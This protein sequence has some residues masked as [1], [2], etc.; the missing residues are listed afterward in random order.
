QPD[1][2]CL[3]L[4]QNPGRVA[5][6]VDTRLLAVAEAEGEI[7]RQVDD[8]ESGRADVQVQTRGAE[9]SGQGHVGRLK[10]LVDEDVELDV[11]GVGR[12]D[13]VAAGG[14]ESSGL[15]CAE[16]RLLRV[17]G[18]GVGIGSMQGREG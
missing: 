8:E 9:V 1:R 18:G 15:Q 17:R 4:V 10:V 12:D 7:D 11:V 3:W 2:Q 14:K 13:D 16:Q 5:V 6:Q